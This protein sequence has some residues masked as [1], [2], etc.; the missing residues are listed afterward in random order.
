MT[1]EAM[2]IKSHAKLGQTHSRCSLVAVW[3]FSEGEIALMPTAISL[4]SLIPAGLSLRSH[5]LPAQ[6]LRRTLRQRCRVRAGASHRPN[7][8]HR[9]SLG[10]GSWRG[11]RGVLCAAADDAGQQRHTASRGPATGTAAFRSPECR[12]RRRLRLPPESP[13]RIDR[14]RS[15]TA[16][17]GNLCQPA[18]RGVGSI[19]A[20]SMSGSSEHASKSLI[21]T[22]AFTQS[23]KRMKTV[24]H[25]PNEAGRSRQG[26]PVRTIHKTASTKRR[27]SFPLRPGSVRLPRQCGS[28]FAHW[29]SVNK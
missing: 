17:R 12:R 4:S 20:N 3:R 16:D 18:V 6:D 22:S 27:L 14:L 19:M 2:A 25:L 5:E 23:R 24:F 26:L 15:R 8:M 28:I 29:A 21:K 11:T 1:G 13:P 9:P 10:P 7:G